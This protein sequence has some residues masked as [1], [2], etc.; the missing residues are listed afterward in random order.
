MKAK[1][2]FILTFALGF[3][4]AN[5]QAI[6]ATLIEMHFPFDGDLLDATGT[7]TLNPKTAATVSTYQLGQIGSSAFFNET[8]YITSGSDFEAGES[9]SISLWIKFNTL[10]FSGTGTPKIIHQEDQGAGF[11]PGRPLQIATANN[12]VNTSFGEAAINSSASPSLDKWVHI[13]IVMDTVAENTK[14]YINGVEDASNTIGNNILANNKKNNAELSI[15]VQKNSTTAG[16]L[17]AYL[18][19]LLITREV[20]TENQIKSVM[21]LGVTKSQTSDTNIWLG[22]TSDY[23]TGSNWSKGMVPVATDNVIIPNG[24]S[25]N[26]IATTAISYNHL[27]IEKEASLDVGNNAITANSTMVFGGGSLIAKSTVSGTFTYNVL[28]AIDNTALPQTSPGVYNSAV[29][30]ILSSPVVGETYDNDWI[31]DYEIGTGTFAN[32]AIGLYNNTTDAD[33]DWEYYQS[34]SGVPGTFSSGIGFLTRKK[35]GYYQSI[36]EEKYPFIGT[37]PEND[38][39]LTLTQGSPIGN[40]WNLVGNPFPSYI[41][42][43]DLIT[44]NASNITDNFETAY[45]WNPI[46]QLYTGLSTSDYIEP[47]QGFF[48]NAA[49][50]NANN[51]VISETLQ[52]HQTG[53]TF[54]RNSSTDTKIKLR[55]TNTISTRETELNFDDVNT[56]GLDPGKD[57]GLFTGSSSAFSLFTHLVSNDEGIAFER[58]A[59]PDANIET[60]IVPI[61]VKANSGDVLTFTVE[62]Q[63]L[64]TGVGVYLEDNATNTFTRLDGTNSQY[65]VTLDQNLNGIGRFYLRTANETLG[66]DNINLSNSVSIFTPNNSKL[67]IIGV[68]TGKVSLQLFDILGK[69]VLSTTYNANANGPRDI[70]LPSLSSGVYIVKLQSVNGL[71]NK[72]IILK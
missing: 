66:L 7:V 29:W 60:T 35:T 23:G 72:K 50:A 28:T 71:L 46:T 52:S 9:Y 39:T 10:V 30:N 24:T 44:A 53:I 38:V 65:N 47:G 15:G 8:P 37:F 16:L 64:P 56:L 40:D 48:I 13:A 31:A 6:D 45:V 26:P 62:T 21:A 3:Q 25:N 2:L 43:S 70:S 22:T 27:L 14:M 58:Q 17:Q 36:D 49:N 59:L 1:L 32:R 12:T 5:A 18:D 42:I 34:N 11:L 33:G 68:E 55:L 41:L 20:L 69:T 63:N 57:I 54:Y 51:F 61:G 4:F 19:D 67:R